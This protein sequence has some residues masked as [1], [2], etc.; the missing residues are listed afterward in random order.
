MENV[1][2]GGGANVSVWNTGADTTIFMFRSNLQEVGE[3]LAKGK[4]TAA[5]ARS[6]GGLLLGTTSN[7]SILEPWSPP[8]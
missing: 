7:F 2:A 1:S 6:L 4:I 8:R 3:Q 5:A